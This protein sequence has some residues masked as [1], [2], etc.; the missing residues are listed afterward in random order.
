MEVGVC[1]MEAG[2]C[3]MVAGVCV[4]GRPAYGGHKGGVLPMSECVRVYCLGLGVGA[5]GSSSEYM[6]TP[7]VHIHTLKS[8]A[9]RPLGGA[10]V[11]GPQC[12]WEVLTLLTTPLSPPP[13]PP[14]PH[15]L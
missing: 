8:T 4:M 10:R 11:R 13:L 3:V 9:R 2:V 1:V 15:S 6:P 14:H 7:H 12:A 5:P